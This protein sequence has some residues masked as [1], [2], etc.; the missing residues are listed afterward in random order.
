MRLSD[1]RSAPARERVANVTLDATV[2]ADWA[3]PETEPAATATATVEVHQPAWSE[4][5]DAVGLAGV[6]VAGVGLAALAVHQRRRGGPQTAPRA[7]PPPVPVRLAGG[8]ARGRAG[9]RR[10]VIAWLLALGLVA[11]AWGTA[12]GPALLGAGLVAWLAAAWLATEG[13]V[14][15]PL[16]ARLAALDPDR[17]GGGL[18]GAGV[19]GALVVLFLGVK[20]AWPFAFASLVAGAWALTRRRL[21]AR[22]GNA[23]LAVGCLAALAPLLS[24]GLTIGARGALTH[25]PLG[26][27]LVRALA[28][29]TP[30]LLGF[31]ALAARCRGRAR[32]GALAG[33]GFVLVQLPVPG[34]LVEQRL[35]LGAA[36]VAGELVVAA[37]LVASA[38][39]GV[40][41]LVGGGD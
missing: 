36:V 2:R 10:R 28:F 25:V 35:P 23:V 24:A 38:L 8:R 20:L 31:G 6:A 7:A 13:R 17:V 27:T 41:T 19:A 15:Q 26:G 33:V 37:V 30:F 29:G 21:P 12:T 11:V 39:P 1:T 40:A 14:P 22:T 4:T 18:I 32:A 3:S 9:L 5:G 34:L 16:E